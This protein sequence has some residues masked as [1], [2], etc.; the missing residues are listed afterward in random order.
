VSAETNPLRSKASTIVLNKRFISFMEK[1]GLKNSTANPCLF[2]CTHE[3]SFLLVA[4]YVDDRFV[5]VNKLEE[6][7][8]FLG[9][10]QEEFK[11]TIGSLENFQ[12]MPIKCQS[13]GLIFVSQE[14]YT[15]KILKE[16]NTAEAK[17][18]SKPASGEERDKHKVGIGKVLYREPVGN[19]MYL[20]AATRPDISYAVSKAARVMDRPTV[21]N[22]NEVKRIF[23]YLRSSSNCGL[24]YTRGSGE[25]KVLLMLTSQEIR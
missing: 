1:A 5:V 6:I 3:D 19:L 16:F 2:Y 4:I 17:G 21:K 25:R 11:I 12:G 14:A 9:L 24:R 8:W 10:L 13:D 18:L 20:A 15:N 7:D 22:W 23:R